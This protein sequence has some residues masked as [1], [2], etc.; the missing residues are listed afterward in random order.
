MRALLSVSDKQNIEVFAKELIDLGFEI[1][2][3]GGTYK[4]LIDAGCKALQV[5]DVTKFDEILDGRVKTLHP[6]I[7]GGILYV[8]DNQEHIETIEKN[9]IQGIDLVCVN[10][11]PFA[12][13]IKRTDDF[14][15]IIENID[16]GGP[17]LIRAAAKNF[18]DCIVV[19]D[20]QDYSSV[21][22]N[23]K[24]KTDNECF[25]KKLMAKAFT[26][27]AKY[28]SVISGYM[29]KDESS[30]SLTGNKVFDTR[31]GENPHQK[32]SLYSSSDFFDKFNVLKGELSFNNL[33]DINACIKISALFRD[34]TNITIVKHGNPCGFAIEDNLVECFKKA[35][36]C[37]PVSAYGGVACIN[38]PVDKSLAVELNSIFLEV[39]VA[40]SFSKDAVVELSRKK[41]VKLVA[42]EHHSSVLPDI[43]NTKDVKMIEGG[44]LVQDRDVVKD[45]EVDNAE[46]K[47][48][49]SASAS[50]REDMKIAYKIASCTKS[51]CIVYVKN[52]YLVAI[53]MG[54][55]SRIDAIKSATSKAKEQN[56][57]ISSCS[58]ASEAFFP[59]KDSVEEASKVGV[60]TIIQPGGSIRDDEVVECAN[61]N[62]IA[63]Y[64]T[65]VRHFLH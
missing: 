11:Y 45:D 35:L 62:N 9:N 15:E 4:A 63:I 6:K 10:L 5:E 64:F 47:G 55:T 12:Q 38:A 59:F 23:I 3:T 8:R 28:D 2:S 1:I 7:H 42:L 65:G 33:L 31:Y 46:Q 53:G 21:I 40:P 43:Q 29:N 49:K 39:I 51:N 52:S 60:S 41:R 25:R 14:E 27:T 17:T 32:A 37:D 20:V 13:T 58:M 57:D 48:S 26:H 22:E 61:E 50:E 44:F 34:K 19:V 30:F 56:I 18:K 54:M 16:I 24:N 36:I